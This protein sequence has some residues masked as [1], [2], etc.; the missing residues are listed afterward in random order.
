MQPRESYGLSLE[1]FEAAEEQV[2]EDQLDAKFE[3][4]VNEL[5]DLAQRASSFHDQSV[6][7]YKK[8][9][10]EMEFN[11]RLMHAIKNAMPE[12]DAMQRKPSERTN[13][14]A[15]M[16][17][18]SRQEVDTMDTW[19]DMQTSYFPAEI[20]SSPVHAMPRM[21]REGGKMLHESLRA[22]SSIPHL[23]GGGNVL[24]LA[25]EKPYTSQERKLNRRL[26]KA[27]G[28]GN[29]TAIRSLIKEGADPNYKGCSPLGFSV[30]HEAVNSK[31]IRSV[32]VLHSLGADV[33]VR[34]SLGWNLLHQAAN[35]GD[36]EMCVKLAKM[37]VSVDTKNNAG[38][39]PSTVA[40]T[41]GARECYKQL[42][43]ME[44]DFIKSKAQ[45]PVEE[46]EDDDDDEEDDD[47][48][49]E[50]AQLKKQLEEER[51]EQ[52]KKL[53]QKKSSSKQ[54]Q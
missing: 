10:S 3:Q 32:E 9:E 11:Q 52:E 33:T 53:A 37:G 46:E 2:Q 7:L 8:I 49:Q 17:L 38:R 51:A 45:R 18:M 40:K 31:Q 36:M 30:M 13:N 41:A 25:E 15:A 1:Q 50:E 4:E 19:D 6:E 43:Q 20:G 34:D 35:N 24:A 5:D 39:T 42:M 21:G 14:V 44:M 23:R 12:I 28:N 48:D 27:V 29:E 47:E 16:G 26:C 22:G 54:K